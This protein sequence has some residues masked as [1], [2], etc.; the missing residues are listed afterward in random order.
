MSADQFRH[1]YFPIPH[2]G[3][4][5]IEAVEFLRRE[6]PATL[7]WTCWA[8][9][10]VTCRLLGQIVGKGHQLTGRIG[11]WLWTRVPSTYPQ[12][13]FWDGYSLDAACSDDWV[14]VLKIRGDCGGEFL[15]FS[16]LNS[17]GEI[18]RWYLASTL[19]VQL[20]DRFAHAVRDHFLPSDRLVIQ[21]RGG[22]NIRLNPDDD[23]TI[24]LTAELRQDIEQQVNSFFTNAERYRQR[25]LR[26]RRGFLFVGSPGTGKS[27]M[28]RHMVRQ[29]HR[30]HH[31]AAFMLNIT[32]DTEDNDVAMLF[33]DAEHNAPCLIIME[34][35][36][37]LTTECRVSR[38]HLLAQLDGLDSREGLL[39]IGTTNNPADVDPALVHRPSRFDRV[40][41]FEL[42]DRAMRQRYLEWAFPE[43]EAD[44]ATLASQTGGWT[45]AYLNE[46]RTTAAILA[47]DRNAAAPTPEDLRE[48]FALLSPQFQAGRKNHVADGNGELTGFLHG[49]R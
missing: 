38:A 1:E 23:E 3:L 36:D 43:A 48:A 33:R 7:S 31:V 46:L 35:L 16:F 6:F 44:A 34:D 39:V 12:L 2:R 18:G 32:K 13:S 45:F 49:S 25:R 26:H 19:N 29:C 10:H 22:P 11:Q 27:M 47:M 15:L 28:L 9:G 24:F 8:P 21:V 40:W 30:R 37:A 4:S 41:H 20:L 14:G 5:S 42:P 17:Q